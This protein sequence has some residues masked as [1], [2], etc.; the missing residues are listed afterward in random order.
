MRAALSWSRFMVMTKVYTMRAT[1][2]KKQMF[3]LILYKSHGTHNANS[4]DN[5]GFAMTT[6]IRIVDMN[7]A[8]SMVR[9]RR[10]SLQREAR[11]AFLAAFRSRETDRLGRDFG[12]P[13]AVL[14]VVDDPVKHAAALSRRWHACW[15]AQE[16]WFQPFDNGLAD[17]ASASYEQL[18]FD[19]RWIGGRA[20]PQ[21]MAF[22][23][24]CLVLPLPDDVPR[25]DLSRSFAQAMIDRRFDTVAHHPARVRQR[26]AAGRRLIAPPRYT[27]EFAQ[28][29][30]GKV[31]LV[32]DLYAFRARD[33]LSVAKAAAASL[34]ILALCSVL[35]EAALEA[36]RERIDA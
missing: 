19:P 22:E 30:Q 4:V 14:D 26:Y 34:R 12:F 18:P 29:C 33:I 25:V 5:R 9:A 6:P 3:L 20:L 11:R 15:A 27:G 23:A 7:A 1:T 35:G 31:E 13:V 36:A 10:P 17:M 16:D 2:D 24:G 32:T 28:A 21:G 8:P